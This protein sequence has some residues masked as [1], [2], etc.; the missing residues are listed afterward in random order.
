LS[1]EG[2]SIAVY[3]VPGTYFKG[4]PKS[5]G[6]PLKEDALLKREGKKDVKPSSVEVFQRDSGP[7]IVYLFPFSAEITGKDEHVDFEAKIGR[8]ILSQTFT[9][10]DMEFHGKLEL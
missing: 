2:Y 1:T 3:G 4:D 7:V 9:L 10:A 5:L 8:I 6:K